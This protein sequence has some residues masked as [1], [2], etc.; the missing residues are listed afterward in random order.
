MQES[1]LSISHYEAK[2][3]LIPCCC[4]DGHVW[5]PLIEQ[6]RKSILHSTP[7]VHLSLEPAHCLWLLFS[8]EKQES[9]KANNQ[10]WAR[11]SLPL[12][13]IISVS[14]PL[15]M[16]LASHPKVGRTSAPQWLWHLLL[17]ARAPCFCQRTDC[18]GIVQEHHSLL[19]P[20][21]EQ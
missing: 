10:I 21:D 7:N 5:N 15:T 17:L 14:N 16:L 18:S 20:R 13:T 3:D 8:N 2:L 4:I 11:V 12:A 19:I 6:R 9:R 1:D